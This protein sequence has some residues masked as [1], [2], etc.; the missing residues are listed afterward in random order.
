LV[1]SVQQTRE[2]FKNRINETQTEMSDAVM[3]AQEERSKFYH[4]VE[5][6]ANEFV[7]KGKE[8][9]GQLEATRSSLQQ[10][11]TASLEKSSGRIQ[12][13]SKMCSSLEG[14]VASHVTGSQ[15]AWQELYSA[16][17]MDLRKHSDHLSAALMT[18]AHLSSE[19]LTSLTAAAQTQEALLEEQRSDMTTM[20]RERQDDTEAQSS[21]FKDWSVLLGA[22]IKQRNDDVVKFLV[23][24]LTHDVPTGQTPQRREFSYPRFLASTS[25]HERIVERFRQE[26]ANQSDE[27]DSDATE[28]TAEFAELSRSSS[29]KGSKSVS[30]AAAAHPASSVARSASM[31][32]LS[33]DS[34]AV[35]LQRAASVEASLNA[36]VSSA[37]A[38]DNK[39]NFA[40][41]NPIPA[42][43]GSGMKQP[44]VVSSSRKVLQNAHNMKTQ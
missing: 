28:E 11:S 5:T 39:E 17:E 9:R 6:T 33:G 19:S 1:N 15:S 41:P 37:A 8:W 31:S 44:S 10:A 34:A 27:S 36:A 32:D 35:P 7:N 23:E 3:K 12:E 26:R 16:Q 22:E 42:K 40:I 29:S 24:D 21:A 4:V 20:I 13:A 25:P 30:S 14:D 38:K 2:S 43:K 18:H